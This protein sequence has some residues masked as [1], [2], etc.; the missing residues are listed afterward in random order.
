VV[1]VIAAVLVGC[2]SASGDGSGRPVSVPGPV[3]DEVTFAP[4]PA[5][6][7]AAPSFE[8]PLLGGGSVDTAE[9]SEQ[10]PIVLVFFETRCE[11]CRA[12]Q[13][14]INEVAEE[15][16]DVVLFLGVADRSEAD[17]LWAYV[18]ENEIAYPVGA[19]GDGDIWLQYAVEEP[20]LVALVSQGGRLVRGWP[21]GVAGPALRDQIDQLV[22]APKP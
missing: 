6:A 14:E 20:P 7:P 17:D 16:G 10:H 11:Q 1:L 5:N 22:L 8:L 9:E 13:R 15:F 18:T 2:S 4:P 21:G 3:P 19:D 12:Q